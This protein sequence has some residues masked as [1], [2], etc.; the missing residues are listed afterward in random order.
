VPSRTS[1][2]PSALREDTRRR[3][4]ASTMTGL[5]GAFAAG[6]LAVWLLGAAVILG[7]LRWWSPG[8]AR[9]FVDADGQPIVGSI[10][11]KVR[12]SVGGT[13]QGGFVKGIDATRPVLLFLHGGPGLP[14]YALTERY[15]THLEEDFVVCWWEQRGSGLSYSRDT[16]R[17]VTEDQ[18]I[19]DTVEVTRYLRE[20]F[21]QDKIFLMAHSGGSHIG[22]QVAARSPELFHAYIGVAQI[23]RQLESE[24]SAHRFMT[25]RFR[26]AG[27]RKMARELEKF[28]LTDTDVVPRAY[29][30]V[31]DKAM[32]QLGIG[33]THAMRSVVTGVFLP[34]WQHPEYTV[35]EK[36]DIWRG[37]WSASSDAL[38]NHMIATDLT[39]TVT[40]LDV[41][42]YFLH[43]IHDQTTSYELARAYF[44]ELRAPLKGFYTFGASAHS[45]LFEEPRKV[46]RIMRSDV[47]GRATHLAD[48]NVDTGSHHLRGTAPSDLPSPPR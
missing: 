34:V 25:A 30:P 10:S 8:T 21:D 2:T 4:G 14:E 15:P 22:I 48:R 3:D 5:V 44:R 11:Q 29:R 23:S 43:G 47:L 27:N 28:P 26:A 16:S 46:Q 6:L 38:W 37:K 17:S 1:V 12:L 41:P 32:H 42:V 9:A 13:R 33:T 24:R 7:V 35:R 31:R 19:A 45:P 36:L 18:L 39:T 40:S 20:R